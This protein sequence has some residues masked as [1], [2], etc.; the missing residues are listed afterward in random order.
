[1]DDVDKRIKDFLDRYHMRDRGKYF[2]KE[3][4]VSLCSAHQTYT[5]SLFLQGGFVIKKENKKSGVGR[6]TIKKI[7]FNNK[8]IDNILL[9]A[10]EWQG[11]V[12]FW[13]KIGGEIIYKNV[14]VVRNREFCLMIKVDVEI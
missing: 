7:F 1:M 3:R 14:T 2:R 6:E 8:Q 13:T 12:G 9:Y 4:W 11:A 5:N 10:I